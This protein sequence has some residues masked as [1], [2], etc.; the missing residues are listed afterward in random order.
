LSTSYKN[1]GLRNSEG[2]SKR[3]TECPAVGSPYPKDEFL[4]SILSQTSPI[5]IHL[6]ISSYKNMGILT[7]K[8]VD[9]IT[10]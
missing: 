3:Y 7:I 5:K 2:S 9:G 1:K 10:I 8:V 4:V 6:K